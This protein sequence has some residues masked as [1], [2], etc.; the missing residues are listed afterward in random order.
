[1]DIITLS[2]KKMIDN[3]YSTKWH[4]EETVL[5]KLL[6]MTKRV[7]PKYVSSGIVLLSV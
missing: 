2:F 3:L 1:M 7:N 5:V 6:E 4:V